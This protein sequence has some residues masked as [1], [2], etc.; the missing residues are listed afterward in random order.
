MNNLFNGKT[1][2][3]MRALSLFPVSAAF[4][5]D[6]KSNSKEEGNPEVRPFSWCDGLPV[7]N[8]YHR[9]EE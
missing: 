5:Q 9:F 2:A 4:A 8:V 7:T 1:A 3:M 6:V